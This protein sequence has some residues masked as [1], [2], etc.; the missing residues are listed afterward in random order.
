MFAFPLPVVLP[1]VF[2]CWGSILAVRSSCSCILSGEFPPFLSTCTLVGQGI[3]LTDVSDLAHRHLL[4]H[5]AVTHVLMER[6]DDRGRV[7]I[8]DV[9]LY[10]AESLDVLAQGLSFLLGEQMKVTLL[11][12]RFVAAC[13]GADKLM[14]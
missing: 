2:L 13:K 7:D 4:P 3:Q 6:A 12:M 1:S 11:A 14:A 9:V 5:P 8:R 10:T